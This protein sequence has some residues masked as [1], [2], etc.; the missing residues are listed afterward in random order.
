MAS[1]YKIGDKFDA[2]G[3]REFGLLE[4]KDII[5]ENN[6]TFYILEGIKFK[7]QYKVSDKDINIYYYYREN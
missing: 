3:C 5:I 1:R 6:T 2:K 7:Y 4:L